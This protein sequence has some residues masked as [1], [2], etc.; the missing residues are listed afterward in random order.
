MEEH[1]C[2]SS[3]SSK[4]DIITPGPAFPPALFLSAAMIGW[5]ICMT[6]SENHDLV[7]AGDMIGNVF[8]WN[9]GE[10]SATHTDDGDV[11]PHHALGG[12]FKTKSYVPKVNC[13]RGVDRCAHT[14]KELS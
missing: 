5:K 13:L 7:V 11:P 8:S 12:P 2:C 3:T 6:Y 14:K 4:N 1:T 10:V 9:I